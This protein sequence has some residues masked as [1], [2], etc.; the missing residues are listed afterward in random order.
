MCL[1]KLNVIHCELCIPVVA[2]SK[3]Y[4]AR[5]TMDE[6]PR[7][8]DDGFQEAYLPQTPFKNARRQDLTM[9]RLGYA[10]CVTLTAWLVLHTVKSSYWKCRLPGPRAEL[11]NAEVILAEENVAKVALEAHIMSKCPD[12]KACLQMLV[13]PA[14][15]QISDMVDFRLSYI[16]RSVNFWHHTH[17]TL[18]LLKSPS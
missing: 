15:E 6:K 13:V 11:S 16:G 9:R 14:M 4:T 17:P 1:S 18:Y 3:S 2:T 7:S 10:I 8:V 12:A 5:R